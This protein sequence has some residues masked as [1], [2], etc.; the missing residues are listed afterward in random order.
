MTYFVELDDVWVSDLLQDSYF[1]VDALEVGMVLD[2][3][4]LQDFY[5]NLSSHEQTSVSRVNDLRN[6]DQKQRRC[7]K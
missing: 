5:G 3:V 1:T 7:V 6:A 2:L 4:L